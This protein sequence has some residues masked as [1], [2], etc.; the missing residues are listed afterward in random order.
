M[1][2]RPAPRMI[3]SVPLGS[4]EVVAFDLETTGLNPT[5]ARVVE[6]GAVWISAGQVREAQ[7]YS[8]L[9]NPGIAI[10]AMSASIHGISD[11]KVAEMPGFS[12]CMNAFVNWVGPNVLI[13]FSIGLDISVLEAEHA[14]HG[15]PWNAPRTLDVEELVQVLAPDIKNYSLES[16]ASWLGI[17]IK[18]RHRAVPDSVL[19]AK[20][21]TTLIPRLTTLGVS[22]FAEA[23][24]ACKDFRSRNGAVAIPE[25]RQLVDPVNVD[26]FRFRN[27]VGDVMNSPP[28]ILGGGEPL[29]NA[30][31][32]M[33]ERRVGGLFIE[34]ETAPR[35]FG[36]LTEGDII[37]ALQV[38]GPGALENRAE[39][40][41]SR[42]LVTVHPKE[43]VYRAVIPMS[44]RRIRHLGVAGDDG[45]VV[46]AISARDLFISN[47]NDAVDLGREIEEAEN[48]AELGRI[49]E[50]LA[51]VARALVNESMEAREIAAIISRELRALTQRACELAEA[52]LVAKG[53]NPPSEPYAMMVLGS[54]GRGESLLA[55]DQDNAIVFSSGGRG[56]ESDAWCETIGRRVAAILN[57]A[58]VKFCTGGVM[59]S[60][61]E[62]RMSYADWTATVSNWIVRT[63]PDDLLNSDIFFDS[64]PVHGDFALA[65]RLRRES[66][67]SARQSLP[68]LRL[69]AQR[70]LGSPNPFGWLGRLRLE[71]GRIDLKMHGVMPIF[72]VARVLA[73]EN[74]IYARSTAERLRAF[75]KIG[76][77]SKKQVDEVILAHGILLA[78][79]LRQQLR[80]LDA[81]IPLSNRIAPDAFSTPDQSQLKWALEQVE[82][83]TGFFG[84]PVPA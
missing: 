12:D 15:I 14:R 76:K 40:H 49:W 74:G 73:L 34:L 41:C 27:R 35:E 70:S 57:D 23:E 6:F 62:W 80:D 19:A 3:G 72:S 43:F 36:I 59:A 66:I 53:S 48:P 82:V 31:S 24:K 58:G 37:R 44:K 42:P 56:S 75:G 81:G 2:F 83:A 20:A 52:E 50:G 64:M 79:I 71:R 46:G 22:S 51:T 8:S 78:T 16:V 29:K 11:E 13:G 60:N 7:Y 10:P 69:L 5:N 55:M 26:S 68:F 63:Q 17:E 65:N 1:S 32:T 47:L 30:V 67:D 4:I 25:N 9:V 21:F 77:A 18:D 33:V 28:I 61:S 45:M 39:K 38:E 54:G 84:I